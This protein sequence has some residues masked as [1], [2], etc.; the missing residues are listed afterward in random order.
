MRED[1]CYLST[2]WMEYFHCTDK[3]TQLRE[4]AK[5]FGAKRTLRASGRICVLNVRE[6]IQA[7]QQRSGVDIEVWLLGDDPDDP[8]HTGIYGYKDIEANP[9]PTVVLSQLVKTE[10]VLCVPSD[11]LD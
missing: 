2:A 3:E 7:C 10:D 4:V 5:A 8:S 6:A 1:E 11:L 9:D